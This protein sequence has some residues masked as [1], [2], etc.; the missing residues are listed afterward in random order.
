MTVEDCIIRDRK[1]P[2]HDPRETSRSVSEMKEWTCAKMTK[3]DGTVKRDCLKLYTGGEDFQICYGSTKDGDTCLCSRELCNGSTSL[4]RKFKKL[5]CQNLIKSST[6]ILSCLFLL[7]MFQTY[8]Q[9]VATGQAYY[10][11]DTNAVNSHGRLI[12]ERVS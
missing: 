10:V 3:P 5:S 6:S 12:R 9:T 8:C 7:L 4:T 2:V 11:M 1:N